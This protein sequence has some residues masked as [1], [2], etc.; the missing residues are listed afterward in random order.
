[1]KQFVLT[2]LAGV[3]CLPATYSLSREGSIPLALLI[4]ILLGAMGGAVATMPQHDGNAIRPWSL[5]L[6][7]V[8]GA[9]FSEAVAF[10]HY[11]ISYGYQDPKLAVGVIVSV[12]EF[13][14]I[15]VIGCIAMLIAAS[16]MH[17]RITR[18]S[19]G[20]TASGAPLS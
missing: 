1:M 3:L 6:A 9:L 18:R 14:V 2:T 11:Y 8:V 10:T 17:S 16:V 20:R 19:K 7:F 15:S 12:F 5:I 13:F 4:L